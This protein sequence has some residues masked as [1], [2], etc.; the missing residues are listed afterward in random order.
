M[1]SQVESTTT[2]WSAS[3]VEL[4][5]DATARAAAKTPAT[6]SLVVFLGSLP[7]ACQ[8]PWFTINCSTGPRLTFTLPLALQTPGVINLSDP[9]IAAADIVEA[10]TGGASCAPPAGPLLNG[11]VEI[12]SSDA[13]G[14]TFKVYQSSSDNLAP[15]W[16]LAFDGL[17]SASFCP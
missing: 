5:S 8:E 10:S 9:A 17:C 14:L 6:D 11:T 4:A 12:L 1:W 2:N 13:G 16:W 7:D 15:G 3:A